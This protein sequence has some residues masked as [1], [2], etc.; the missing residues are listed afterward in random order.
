MNT[1]HKSLLILPLILTVGACAEPADPT[2]EGGTDDTGTSTDSAGETDTGTEGDTDTPEAECGNGVVEADEECDAGSMNGENATCTPECSIN[3]CGD[4]Y[5]FADGLEQCDDGNDL[6]TD[7]CIS[8]C[9]LP[10]CGDGFVQEGVETC[11]DGNTVDGD[12]CSAECVEQKVVGLALGGDH[13]C[14]LLNTGNV[15]CWGS[16]EYGLLGYGNTNDIG[17]DEHPAAAGDVDVGGTVVQ[18]SASYGHTCALLDGGTV[19][20]WGINENG[21]LGYP[22]L[23]TVGDDETPASVGDVNVGGTVVQIEA[24]GLHTCALLETG[25]VRCWG[26]GDFGQLG[27]GNLENIGDD[28][29]PSHAGDVQLGSYAANQ[30]AAGL[31]GT[32]AVQIFGSV[33]CWGWANSGQLGYGNVEQIGDDETPVAAGTVPIGAKVIQVT[34]GHDHTCIRLDTGD[35]RCW[36]SNQYGKLGHPFVP[37][38]IGDDELPTA[39]GTVEVGAAVTDISIGGPFGNHTCVV[40]ETGGV[41]CWGNGGFGRLGYGD[42][43]DIGDNEEPSSVGDVEIDGVAVGVVAGGNH[44]CALLDTG[45]MRCW[46]FNQ[47]GQLGIASTQNIGDDELPSAVPPVR[48]F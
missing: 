14:A 8:D 12:G 29:N 33:R 26:R 15:R 42:V 20:C 13:T 23:G 11:D 48:V 28:E 4:G 35:V 6:D 21:Q 5:M 16:G 1:T 36:G 47:R 25:K 27:Y 22:G 46:G 24:G 45:V 44:T 30:I 40:T 41:R 3:V 10:A 7:E 9:T 39:V 18:I 17:D 34:M 31:V 2:A 19:R 43:L 37:G 38:P 32:C